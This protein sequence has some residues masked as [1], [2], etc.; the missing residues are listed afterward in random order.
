[1]TKKDK[2]I[3]QLLVA[4]DL[5]RRGWMIVDNW[6]ADLC[7]VGIARPSEP[8]RLVYVSTFNQPEGRYYYECDVPSGP[9]ETDFER[10]DKGDSVTYDELLIVLVRHLD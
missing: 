2:T 5:E 3:T 9:L 8:R 4:L 7:A 10:T 6:D 1:M